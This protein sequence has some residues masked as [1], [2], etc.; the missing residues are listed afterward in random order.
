[1]NDDELRKVIAE[2]QQK[3]IDDLAQSM[4]FSSVMGAS[5]S[6]CAKEP[7]SLTM[8][9]LRY[10]I[11]AIEREKGTSKPEPQRENDFRYMGDVFGMRTYQTPHAYKTEIKTRGIAAKNKPNSHKPYY[12]RIVVNTPMAYIINGKETIIHP[13]LIYDFGHIS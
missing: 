10:A 12:R 8:D 2:M 5:I 1:M 3:M 7:V 11:E 6:T 4:L 13:A 9:S